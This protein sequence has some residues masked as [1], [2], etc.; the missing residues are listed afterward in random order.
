MK[1]FYRLGG[2]AFFLFTLNI[3]SLY[4][5]HIIGGEL[6]YNCLGGNNYKFS[7]TVYSECGSEAV[8]ESFYPIRYYAT[9]LNI[10]PESPLSFNVFKISQQ[11]VPLFCDALLTDCSGGGARGVEKV[12]YEGTVN[13][14]GQPRAGDW[15]FFWKRSARSEQITTLL[16]PEEEDFFLDAS[17]NNLDVSCNNSPSFSNSAVITACIN[18]PQTLNNATEERDGDVLRYSLVTPKSDYNMDVVFKTGYNEQNF[19]TFPSTPDLSANTGDLMFEANMLEIGITDFKVEEYRN[20]KLIGWVKRA[21]QMTTIDCSNN[22]PVL[23][24]FTSINTDSISVCAGDSI[25]LEIFA[26][27][28]DV[29]P[30]K[31]ELLS[32]D[33]GVF[34]VANNNSTV[35]LGRFRW[36]TTTSDVGIYSFVV[37]VS[38]DKCPEPGI[39]TKTYQIYVNL[40]L[41]DLGADLPL[42]CNARVLLAPTVSGGSGDYTYAWDDGSFGT[43]LNAGIGQYFLTINDNI[44]GCVAKDSIT[45]FPEFLPGFKADSLCFGLTTAFT[46]TTINNSSTK[47]IASWLWDFGDGT[48][49]TSKDPRHTYTASGR[50][51]VK[52]TVKDDAPAPCTYTISKDIKI[53]EPPAVNVSIVG[54]C[55]S[56]SSVTV[57]VFPK[58]TDP[59][60]SFS[61]VIVDFGDGAI[62]T[63]IVRPEVICDGTVDDCVPL[64]AIT[65]NAIPHAY[66]TGGTYTAEVKVKNEFSCFSSTTESTKVLQSPNLNIIPNDFYL[67]CSSPDSLIK[68]ELLHPGNGKLRYQWFTDNQPTSIT[69]ED[70]MINVP[71]TYRVLVTDDSACYDTR[72]LTVTYPLETLFN[73][74][75]YCQKGD[76]VAFLD[77]SISATNTLTQWQWDFGDPASGSR[78]TSN[79]TNPTHRFSS[80]GNYIVTLTVNDSDGCSTT[81]KWPVY[82][83]GIDNA[84]SVSPASGE[85]CLNETITGTGV[86]GT[87]INS[88]SWDLDNGLILSSKNISYTYPASGSYDVSYNVQYNF[89]PFATDTCFADFQQRVE[90]NPLPDVTI[91]T[92]LNRYCRDEEVQF[93][94][95][96]DDNIVS[97]KWEFINVKKGTSQTVEA[98]TS[99]YT[100]TERSNYRIELS[101]TDDQG[102]ETRRVINQFIDRLVVPDFEGETGICPHAPLIIT[103]VFRDTLENITDYRWDFGDG[104]FIE[105]QVPIPLTEHIYDKGGNYDVTLTVFNSFSG[106]ENSISKTVN[107]LMPPQTAF[108]YDTICARNS[109]TFVNTSLPGDG[110]I[111]AYQWLFPDGSTSDSEN[112][113][114]FFPDPGLHPVSL[115]ATSSLGCKDTVTNEVFVK[116]APIARIDI[117]TTF[118]EAFKPTTFFDD[119][120]GTITDYYWD[121]GDGTISYEKDPIHTYTAIDRYPLVHAVVNSV[122]CTDTLEIL[123]DLNVYLEL[124]TA[125]S[126]NGDD[127][128][129]VLRLIHQGIDN[130]IDFKLYDRNGLIV[131]NGSGNLDA[132]WDGTY[133]GQLQPSGVYLAQVKATGAYGKQFNY[134]KNIT[135]IR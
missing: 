103:E 66:T 123:L 1:S 99:S 51:S 95:E 106:C 133:H 17:L 118:V 135:L 115:V 60:N 64:P 84:F 15:R 18:S 134:K 33:P 111:Q 31:M 57:L 126:P 122:G 35:P 36:R 121:F 58:N 21:I 78:N 85:I 81:L 130:L 34:Q 2:F 5:T 27:D 105:G 38:D 28:D 124:P 24:D 96:T 41:F 14:S 129:D 91:T 72:Q 88:E 93:A 67:V 98:F 108:T 61:E 62:D 56:P 47:N 83:T 89:N 44:T 4:A 86:S 87:H 114:F 131:F 132:A 45:L 48:T 100:F 70:I 29:V 82:N 22:L 59:C 107:V 73:Y 110:D 116:E 128:N 12:L 16:L 39:T 79:L 90:V 3:S 97:A 68:T 69:S 120:E 109:A 19:L 26:Q 75:P 74:E 102:C 94:F 25:S 117:M 30:L 55:S 7:L 50:Y 65:C 119:S 127:L 80:E 9:E 104:S 92:D 23:S 53:C 63:C 101:V 52:L 11:E 49:S 37:S 113:S 6:T 32:G 125:F 13:L 46:D 76:T 71:G 77:R 40:P 20:G 43:S 42:N 112:A 8:L 54:R 10:V